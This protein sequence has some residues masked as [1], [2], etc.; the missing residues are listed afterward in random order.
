MA[1]NSTPQG[2]GLNRSGLGQNR[3]AIRIQPDLTN[4][5]RMDFWNFEEAAKLSLLYFY[6]F[7]N[8][9]RDAPDAEKLA[10]EQRC[11]LFQQ[12]ATERYNVKSWRPWWWIDKAKSRNL[13][14]PS[15]IVEALEACQPR[16]T[17]KDQEV[18][19]LKQQL[20]ALGVELAET[21]MKAKDNQS[22]GNFKV[23]ASLEKLVLGMAIEQYGY[24][25]Q[26]LRNDAPSQIASDLE[27]AN[28]SI[29]R[30]TVLARLREAYSNNK[31]AIDKAK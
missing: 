6:D 3:P 5:A 17:P 13:D 8:G 16:Q 2:H 14:F 11:S 24:D 18:E 15:E 9:Q 26:K 10:F 30:D 31:D 7:E 28:L 23:L 25:P 19:R 22:D 1:E 4:W 29:D 12:W 20:T 27:L 21:K